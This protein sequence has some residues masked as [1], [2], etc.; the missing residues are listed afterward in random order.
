MIKKILCILI[1][2]IITP[3]VW[4][5]GNSSILM[6]LISIAII[7]LYTLFLIGICVEPVKPK[8][9]EEKAKELAENAKKYPHLLN[10]GQ[11]T[12]APIDPNFFRYEAKYWTFK[13]RYNH[14]IHGKPGSGL[15]SSNFDQTRVHAGQQGERELAQM[16]AYLRIPS[17][18]VQTFWS[19][20]IPDTSLNTDVDAVIAFN[21]HIILVDAK[22]YAAGSTLQYQQ[23]TD[24]AYDNK[25]KVVDTTTGEIVKTYQFTRNMEIA[26]EQ[27]QRM[28]SD[29]TV[30]GVVLLCP[31]RKGIAGIRGNILVCKGSIPV[32]S[33]WP[34][35]QDLKQYLDDLR[36]QEKL[37]P[38]PANVTR[39]LFALI[40][41]EDKAKESASSK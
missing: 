41:R 21:Q 13:L 15:S 9:T 31:T 27:Y 23:N 33:S 24:E 26:L 14:N 7:V 40:K 39:K 5:W 30:E 36:E 4:N 35:L 16:M 11:Q 17:K 3:I 38:P 25:I 22:E 10:T 32:T 18:E 6:R 8:T 37:C 29:C 12:Q 20:R 1:W 34:Y 2:L 28:F 19:M